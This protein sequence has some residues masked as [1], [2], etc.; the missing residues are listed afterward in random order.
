M[1]LIS[2]PILLASGSPS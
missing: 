2:T 1:P